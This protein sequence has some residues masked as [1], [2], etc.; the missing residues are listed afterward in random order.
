MAPVL[1]AP[2]ALRAETLQVMLPKEPCFEMLPFLGLVF[3]FEH[4]PPG[5]VPLRFG[6]QMQGEHLLSSS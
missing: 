4:V 1:W 5:Q 2:N 3:S 6:A